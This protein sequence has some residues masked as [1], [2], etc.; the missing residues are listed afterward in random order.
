MISLEEHN[1]RVIAFEAKRATFR[2]ELHDFMRFL[3][4]SPF[5]EQQLNRELAHQGMRRADLHRGVTIDVKAQTV[6]EAA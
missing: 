6:E 2:R 1:R 4:V 3:S 5:G